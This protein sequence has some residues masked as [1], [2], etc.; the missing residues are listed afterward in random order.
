MSCDTIYIVFNGG[1]INILTKKK[2]VETIKSLPNK[3]S[4]YA[5]LIV[6]YF[7]TFYYLFQSKQRSRCLD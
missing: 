1:Y 6:V 7:I 4:T 3:I 2:Q 5:M